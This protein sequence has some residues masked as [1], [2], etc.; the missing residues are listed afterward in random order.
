MNG[1]DLE[2]GNHEREGE[3]EKCH[4]RENPHRLVLFRRKEGV[5]GFSQLV[6]GIGM[7]HDVVVEAIVFIREPSKVG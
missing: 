3:R 6:Q 1:I 4:D 5:V 7:S 2:Y